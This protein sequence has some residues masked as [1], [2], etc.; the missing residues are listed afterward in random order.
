MLLYRCDYLII[1][2][3]IDTKMPHFFDKYPGYKIFLSKLHYCNMIIQEKPKDTIYNFFNKELFPLLKKYNEGLEEDYFEFKTLIENPNILKSRTYQQIWENSCKVFEE[4][5]SLSLDWVLWIEN[6]KNKDTP[7]AINYYKEKETFINKMNILIH[8]E[9]EVVKSYNSNEL[10]KI[11]NLQLYEFEQD[12][13]NKN[14]EED[15][16]DDVLEKPFNNFVFLPHELGENNESLFPKNK[17]LN[18]DVNRFIF[19]NKIDNIKSNFYNEKNNNLN[20][21]NNFKNNNLKN[22]NNQNNNNNISNNDNNQNNNNI[23][24]INS[25]NSE[26]GNKRHSKISINSKSSTKSYKSDLRKKKIIKE[27][28]FKQLKRENVDKKILRKFKKFLKHKLKD[29]T[30][31]E[32]KNYI[33]NNEFWPEY[34]KNN[35]MP[36]FSYEKENISFKS[37]NTQYLCWFFE[38]KF[39]LELFNIFIKNNYDDLLQLIENTYNLSEKADD[40]IL[41]KTYLNIMPLI[42]GKETQN[43][44]TACSSNDNKPIDDEIEIKNNNISIEEEDKKFDNMIIENDYIH[45]INNINNITSINNVSDLGENN[46]IL[47]NNINKINISNEFSNPQS[48]LCGNNTNMN[49]NINSGLNDNGFNNTNNLNDSFEEKDMINLYLNGYLNI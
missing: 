19:E 2:S 32:V 8:F 5:L 44:S 29:K 42:Y 24:N 36:P 22:N 45:D 4:G 9:K 43:R 35:L 46:N 12:L 34:I 17:I 28:K 38:H 13:F 3:S 23:I 15:D 31:N 26:S 25:D 40:F 47:I 37:F 7:K 18:D 20:K 1:I 6:D 14:C 30:D 16:F 48:F 49:M 11:H 33:K 41:L 39:A 27:F 10:N 21:I